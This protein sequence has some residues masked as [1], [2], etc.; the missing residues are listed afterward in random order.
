MDVAWLNSGLRRTAPK[1]ESML[2]PGRLLLSELDDGLTPLPDLDAVLICRESG[3][4]M[5][6]HFYDEEQEGEHQELVSAVF[7][8]VPARDVWRDLAI[9][10]SRT[11]AAWPKQFSHPWVALLCH[12]RGRAPDRREVVMMTLAIALA[13]A[14]IER[15]ETK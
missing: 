10:Y 4:V 1:T 8:M 2:E 11:A 13:S 5:R 6:A 7:S 12:A 9:R 15:E 3:E 14:W